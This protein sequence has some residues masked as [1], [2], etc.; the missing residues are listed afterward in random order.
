MNTTEKAKKEYQK[1]AESLSPKSP[2]I[3]N[4][5]WAFLSGGAIC[6]LGE[7]L[8]KWFE[9]YSLG[10]ENTSL[11]VN[12]VLIG[13]SVTLTGFGIYS[14]L[15]KRCGAGTIVPITGFAN[16]MSSPSIEFKTEGFILGIGAKMFTVAGPVLVYGLTTS[17][18]VGV[19]YYLL[20]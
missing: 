13:A 14:K 1:T 2:V 4:C 10:K 9:I 3:K 12:I 17:M 20:R 15:G 19:L 11:L 7:I 6:T 5:I 16:S 18:I 8:K